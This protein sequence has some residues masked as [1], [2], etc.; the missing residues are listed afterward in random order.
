[1]PPE[2][3]ADRD[4]S[5]RSLKIVLG[6]GNPGERYSATRHNLGYR[7]LDGLARR[8]GAR[9]RRAG[10]F[11]RSAWSTRIVRPSGPVVLAKPRTYM[12]RS[13]NAAVALCRRYG[14]TPGEILVVYDDADLELGRLR[15]RPSGSAGGHNGLQSI[16]DALGSRE[17]PR[18][19]LGVRG[20]RRG[21]RELSEYVLSEFGEE[22]LPVADAL[23]DLGIESVE[24]ILDEGLTSAM[25]RFNARIAAKTG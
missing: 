24:T 19:R 20:E 11:D 8:G 1:M 12:N 10:L 22:E 25:N 15:I 5:V 4:R 7:V 13:G 6:L 2:R 21:D 18:L 17:I 23:V 9:F 14:A 16:V 3:N